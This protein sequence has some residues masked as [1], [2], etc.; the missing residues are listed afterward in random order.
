MGFRCQ[1][2]A[3][4]DGIQCPKDAAR[5]GQNTV[6]GRGQVMQETKYSAPLEKLAGSMPFRGLLKSPALPGGLTFEHAFP[7]ACQ[8]LHKS[9]QRLPGQS[10]ASSSGERRTALLALPAAG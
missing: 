10:C 5:N 6:Y 1:F 8:P 2:R 7:Y 4:R 3:K 9:A